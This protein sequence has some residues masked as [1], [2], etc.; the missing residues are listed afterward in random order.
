M[1]R[2]AVNARSSTI[3][4]KVA[5]TETVAYSLHLCQLLYFML[6]RHFPIL[7]KLGST[8]VPFFQNADKE[9]ETTT[10]VQQFL[11]NLPILINTVCSLFHTKNNF[12]SNINIVS[13]A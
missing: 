13:F 8:F 11:Q 9:L 1:P 7:G 5:A 4:M 12:I 6:I 3:N 10:G 2:R